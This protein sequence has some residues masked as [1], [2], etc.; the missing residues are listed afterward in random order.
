MKMQV[1]VM[2]LVGYG[3]N[4]SRL[5]V[6]ETVHGLLDIMITSIFRD[7]CLQYNHFF[8]PER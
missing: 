1:I 4:D 3:S 5:R 7:Y 2:A 6:W 8:E